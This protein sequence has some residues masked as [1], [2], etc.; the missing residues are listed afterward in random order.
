MKQLSG[1]NELSV[2]EEQVGV[3]GP[4]RSCTMEG[5]VGSNGSVTR[6]RRSGSIPSV[7]GS[8][9]RVSSKGLLSLLKCY[10]EIPSIIG[11]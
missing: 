10:I 9:W 1:K 7:M 11:H 3:A 2:S 8:H 5:E 6:V 4:R